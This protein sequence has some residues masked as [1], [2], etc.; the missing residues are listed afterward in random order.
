MSLYIIKKLIKKIILKII[1]KKFINISLT[2]RKEIIK[3]KLEIKEWNE[4][5]MNDINYSESITK[6]ILWGL[7]ASGIV[8]GLILSF[9]SIMGLCTTACAEGHNYRLLQLKFEHVG[10]IFFLTT[11]VIHFLSLNSFLFSLINSGLF[12]GA[13]GSELYFIYLQKYVIKSWCPVCLGIATAVF[14]ILIAYAI[15]NFMRFNTYKDGRVMKNLL[16]YK[17]SLLAIGIIGFLMAFSG[18]TKINAEEQ[19]LGSI[20]KSIAFGNID[21]PVEVFIFTDW[22]CPACVRVEPIIQ[23]TIP[24]I[25]K[26]SQ[27]YFI[28]AFIHYESLNFLPYNLS[29]MINNKKDYFDIRTALSKVSAKTDSPTDSQI[30][31][32]I[33]PLNVTYQELSYKD[34]AIATKLF[35]N[36]KKQF[37]ITKTP[38][39]VIVNTQ[40]KKGKKLK[41]TAEIT[42]SKIIEAVKELKAESK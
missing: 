14:F 21:S 4:S 31:A 16:A 37:S 1:F 30:N 6:R 18:T 11:L 8:V 39:I 38:M 33:K 17:F 7:I 5:Y 40:T 12:A 22:F 42:E 26:E 3:M 20:K 28:D 34:I 29:F 9:L 32:A 36:F 13:A 2:I 24:Q 35:R 19:I 15:F 23:K 27:I 41:G 25:E 10:I